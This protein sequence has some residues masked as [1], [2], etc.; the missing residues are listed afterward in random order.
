MLRRRGTAG[1][2]AVTFAATVAVAAVIMGGGKSPLRASDPTY[3]SNKIATGSSGGTADNTYRF[4]FTTYF[5]ICDADVVLEDANG[6]QIP[7]DANNNIHKVTVTA[8]GGTPQSHSPAANTSVRADLDPQIPPGDEGTLFTLD[9]HAK[10]IK[11]T[12]R[13]LFSFSTRSQGQAGYTYGATYEAGE[14]SFIARPVF[15]SSEG[16]VPPVKNI[17]SSALTFGRFELA[18]ALPDIAEVSIPG[19]S[20]AVT[21]APGGRSFHFTG[22][23][24]AR[25][26]TMEVFV[27][28]ATPASARGAILGSVLQNRRRGPERSRRRVR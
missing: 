21:V 24:L 9:V 6:T 20:F 12:M 22:D 5:R 11:S 13:F 18:G 15:A 17:G 1:L 3:E 27:R 25:G 19:R 14:G 4:T 8:A 2:A 7:N 28:F 26:E 16:F 23:S 10:T